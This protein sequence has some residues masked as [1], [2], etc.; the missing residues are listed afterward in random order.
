MID[1][2]SGAVE[3]ALIEKPFPMGNVDDTVRHLKSLNTEALGY[4]LAA[5]TAPR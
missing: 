2:S 5:A 4:G 1:A 3:T